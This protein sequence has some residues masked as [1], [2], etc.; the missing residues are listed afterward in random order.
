M[1]R[2]WHS[3][4]QTAPQAEAHITEVI[5]A[6]ALAP[7]VGLEPTTL[8][9]TAACS[10]ERSD[11]QRRIVG[12]IA[13]AHCRRIAPFHKASKSEFSFIVMRRKETPPVARFRFQF[14]C[15]RRFGHSSDTPLSTI[16]C[17]SAECSLAYARGLYIDSPLVFLSFCNQKTFVKEDYPSFL[18]FLWKNHEAGLQLALVYVIIYTTYKQ[19][20]CFFTWTR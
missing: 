19:I 10:T 3:K 8:R 18:L 7:P 17:I 13:R 9:L 15:N 20:D 6:S 4:V 14:Y 1:S 12:A 11:R 16:R 2:F 5:W